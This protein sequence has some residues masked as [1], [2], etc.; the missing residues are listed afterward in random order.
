MYVLSLYYLQYITSDAIKI[1]PK[2]VVK[3]Y[4]AWFDFYCIRR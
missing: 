1:E 3:H 4:Y 2:V